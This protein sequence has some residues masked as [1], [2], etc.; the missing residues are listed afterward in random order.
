MNCTMAGMSN[1]LWISVDDP[2]VEPYAMRTVGSV[3]EA[4]VL[5]S[6]HAQQ[7][8]RGANDA[9]TDYKWGSVVLSDPEK[10]IVQGVK[11]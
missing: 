5:S 1:T 9:Y 4:S 2:N 7:V 6:A 11:K 8:A 3:E 10:C